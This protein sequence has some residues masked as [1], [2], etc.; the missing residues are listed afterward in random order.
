VT[1]AISSASEYQGEEC[2]ERTCDREQPMTER[3]QAAN[4]AVLRVRARRAGFNEVDPSSV[5]EARADADFTHRLLSA[6]N[7]FVGQP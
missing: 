2:E 3:G 4:T 7:G 6:S 1:T 5:A